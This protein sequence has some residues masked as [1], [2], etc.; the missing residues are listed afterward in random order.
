MREICHHSIPIHLLHWYQKLEPSSIVY[1]VTCKTVR[2]RTADCKGKISAKKKIKKN[3]NFSLHG[4]GS[5]SQHSKH[6]SSNTKCMQKQIPD[7]RYAITIIFGWVHFIGLHI[8][9]MNPNHYIFTVKPSLVLRQ[10]RFPFRTTKEISWKVLL[11]KK[12]HS[13]INFCIKNG[14]Q[15]LQLGEITGPLFFKY[16]L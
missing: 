11:K 12:L 1:V 10:G 16:L 15:A 7:H 8:S 14:L 9:A 4:S 13:R 5:I 2:N 6:T 3:V